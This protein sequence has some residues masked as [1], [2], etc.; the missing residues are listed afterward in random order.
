MLIGRAIPLNFHFAKDSERASKRPLIVFVHHF[1]GSSTSSK[2]H[3]NAVND[4]G[5]DAVTFSLSWHGEKKRRTVPVL[6]MAHWWK[7]E[8]EQ[9]LE[10][11][12]PDRQKITF[13]FSGPS[14]PTLSVV[15]D[16]LKVEARSGAPSDVV[17][18]IC[19]SG[20]FVDA[21]RCTRHMI[22]QVYGI[23][24]TWQREAV[25]A[26]MMMVWGPGHNRRL[27]RAISEIAEDK[28]DYPILSIRGTLDTIV[29]IEKIRKAFASSNL[30]GL[31]VFE[32]DAGHLTAL[33]DRPAEYKRR[34]K[35]VL[36]RWT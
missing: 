6:M 12:G 13:S 18:S 17:A 34:L 20:P 31:E 2:R 28:P 22:E 8:I 3:V 24:R 5:F 16:R 36:S 33:R 30:A 26:S 27:F 1:G 29:P 14:A 35:A 21:W 23:T 19:D 7:K 9:V 15:A 32:I 10:Q 4:L 11:V 25:L